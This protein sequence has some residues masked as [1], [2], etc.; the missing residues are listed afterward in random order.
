MHGTPKEV[1]SS[2]DVLKKTNLEPPVVLE[3]FRRLTKKGILSSSLPL[4][5]NLKTL[6]KYIED[7]K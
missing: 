3:L 1:F 2:P 6:E 5:K 7:I 4:P